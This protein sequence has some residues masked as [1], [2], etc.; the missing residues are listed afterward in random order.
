MLKPTTVRVTEEFLEE[1][2][3]FIKQMKLDRSAYLRQI[4][5]RGFREDKE[6]RLLVKYAKGEFSAE[7][8]CANLNISLWDLL[9]L[10]KRKNM[11]L[12]VSLEDWL[13]AENL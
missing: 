8:V 3:K 13:D 7:E 10:L 1:L 5:E 11:T 12:N 2:S 9:E 6:E 4:L